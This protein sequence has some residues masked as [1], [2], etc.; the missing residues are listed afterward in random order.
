MRKFN[1]K[2]LYTAA[3]AA[4]ITASAIALPAWG[5]SG[6]GQ[7]GQ[8]HAR[9]PPLPMLPPPA[10]AAFFERGRD[11]APNREQLDKLTD[12][13]KENGVAVPQPKGHGFSIELPRP[14]ARSAMEKAAKECGL[15]PPPTRGQLMPLTAKQREQAQEAM[16][17]LNQCMRKNGVDLP[18]PP[19]LPGRN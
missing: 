11:A 10:G 18:K 12:C 7:S 6:G 4:A 8:A 2:Y 9:R 14:E 3:V 16:K 13:L 15:P 19:A 17:S 1:L 5:D